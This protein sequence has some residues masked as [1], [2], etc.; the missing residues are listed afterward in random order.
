MSEMRRAARSLATEKLIE[1]A[2]E[3]GD[4]N[5]LVLEISADV[6]RL[7]NGEVSSEVVRQEFL[8]TAKRMRQ[9]L[10]PTN[11]EQ[12][13]LVGRTRNVDRDTTEAVGGN[14]NA[15]SAGGL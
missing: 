13:K 10:L 6:E 14:E 3:A 12:M 5:A 7:F 1:I 8:T 4:S 9:R 11:W 15:K 2:T